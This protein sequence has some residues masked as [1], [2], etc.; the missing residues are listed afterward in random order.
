MHIP[1]WKSYDV[2]FFRNSR[3]VRLALIVKYGLII[4]CDLSHFNRVTWITN[5]WFTRTSYFV[6]AGNVDVEA[7]NVE[8]TFE[9]LAKPL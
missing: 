7:G 5:S 6:Q 9:I 1:F 2:L 4:K 3:L 8:N